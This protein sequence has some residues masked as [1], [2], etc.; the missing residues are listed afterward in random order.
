[1]SYTNV[2]CFNFIDHPVPDKAYVSLLHSHLAG[3][4]P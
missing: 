2:F 4:P 3:N 1:M